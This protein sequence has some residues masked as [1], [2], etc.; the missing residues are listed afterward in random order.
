MAV[1]CVAHGEGD[2]STRVGIRAHGRP[3]VCTRCA[4]KHMCVADVGGIVGCGWVR[5]RG[6]AQSVGGPPSWWSSQ[7]PHVVLTDCAPTPTGCSSGASCDSASTR[8]PNAQLHTRQPS[9]RVPTTVPSRPLFSCDTWRFS[10]RAPAANCRPGGPRGPPRGEQGVSGAHESDGDAESLL[11][12]D[13]NGHT[14]RRS[15]AGLAAFSRCDQRAATPESGRDT[16]QRSE[17]E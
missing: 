2:G 6:L 5:S 10:H 16:L 4:W 15:G 3:S 9:G 1:G 17:L 11:Q 8:P 14:M 13:P 7:T 12:R